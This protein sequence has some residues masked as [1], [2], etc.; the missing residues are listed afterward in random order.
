LVARHGRIETN[1]A[2][3]FAFGS[4]RNSGEYGPILERQHGGWFAN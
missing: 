2:V 4:K 1:F 3:D